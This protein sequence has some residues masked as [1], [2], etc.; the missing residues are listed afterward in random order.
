MN[1]LF[2][3][4]N[5]LQPIIIVIQ[6]ILTCAVAKTNELWKMVNILFCVHCLLRFNHLTKTMS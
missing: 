4:K 3:L 2:T 6:L 5:K 1:E